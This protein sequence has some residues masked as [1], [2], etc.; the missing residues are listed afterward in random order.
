MRTASLVEDIQIPSIMPVGLVAPDSVVR[1]GD[2][3][4]V[5]H[6]KLWDARVNRLSLVQMPRSYLH[7]GGGKDLSSNSW[8][9]HPDNGNYSMSEV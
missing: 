8:L 7:S 2:K 5:L 4:D 9:H 3:G 6:V 1:T